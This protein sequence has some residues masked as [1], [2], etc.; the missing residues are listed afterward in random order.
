MR[1]QRKE[2]GEVEQSGKQTALQNCITFVCTTL[3]Y[4][5]ASLQIQ[6]RERQIK[7]EY[8][9]LRMRR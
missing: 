9:P 4:L 1:D 5:T 2:T 3:G 8:E 6:T 7:C